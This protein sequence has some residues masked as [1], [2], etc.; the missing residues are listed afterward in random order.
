[1]S[2]ARV[3]EVTLS[4][5]GRRN[6][7]T[8][9]AVMLRT[10][11]GDHTLVQTYLLVVDCVDVCPPLQQAKLRGPCHLDNAYFASDYQNYS[12]ACSEAQRTS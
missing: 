11:E 6:I 5:Q 4:I 7:G 12:F 1:M 8:K 9:S 3:G 2:L 10:L